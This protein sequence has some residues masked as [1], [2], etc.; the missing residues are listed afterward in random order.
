MTTIQ[1]AQAGSVVANGGLLVRPR[2]VLKKGSETVPSDRRPVRVIKPET[3]I[4]MRQ[5]MEGV[6]L[7]GTGTAA[8]LDGY[9]VGGKTGLGANLRL[10]DA[11]TTRTAT[12]APSWASRRS[13]TRRS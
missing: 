3:A 4:T 11:S 13:P 6:V 5:M 9:T 8:R 1:L 10:R 2:L 12:T 7:H